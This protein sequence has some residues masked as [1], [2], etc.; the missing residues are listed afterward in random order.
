MGSPGSRV[1]EVQPRRALAPW[2]SRG[3]V[4]QGLPQGGLRG[5]PDC[6]E[7]W[8]PAEWEAW[9]TTARNPHKPGI[10]SRAPMDTSYDVLVVFALGC[11]GGEALIRRARGHPLD[12]REGWISIA[13]GSISYAIGLLGELL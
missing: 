1:G 8:V 10:G 12:M 6:P 11:M 3:N 7:W 9:T 2:R 13:V 5:I 4:P